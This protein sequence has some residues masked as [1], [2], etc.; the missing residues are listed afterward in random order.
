MRL[1]EYIMEMIERKKPYKAKE[2]LRTI[3][4]IRRI[5]EECDLFTLESHV[6]HPLPEVSSCRVYLGDQ[7]FAGLNIGTNGKGM[8]PRYALA[9][10]YGEW[11][12]RMQNGVLFPVRQLKFAQKRMAEEEGI[13]EFHEL[14]K[15]ENLELDFQ[16]GPDEIYLTAR[17]LSDCC[18]DILAK[19]FKGVS[20]D[21]MS[22]F[23][24]ESLKDMEIPCLPYFSVSTKEIRILPAKI[25]WNLCGT[26]GMSAGNTSEEA[27]IQGLS[28]VLERYAI[29]Q[30]YIERLTP[31]DI[32]LERY[33]G[34]Q[35]YERM[36]NL[37]RG[38]WKIAVKD[39]S[40]G[41]GLPVI[42]LL[43]ERPDGK[44]AFHLGADPSPV[45]ALERC[46]TE[47][48]QGNSKDNEQRYHNRETGHTDEKYWQRQYYETVECG[49][50][51]WPENIFFETPSYEFAGF[52]QSAGSSDEEDLVYITSLIQE[53]GYQIFV[54]DVSFLGI[55]AY[56]V[57]IPGMSETDFIFDFS[58]EDFKV[59]MKLVRSHRTMLNLTGASAQQ[60]RELA[61]AVYQAEQ[62]DMPIAFDIRRWFP[63][64]ISRNAWIQD[65]NYALSVIY[66][67][68][69]FYK[70]AARCMRDYLD[71]EASC[72]G[73][74]LYNQALAVYWENR[75]CGK[76]LQEIEAELSRDFNVSLAARIRSMERKNGLP[77]EKLFPTCFDCK[78]CGIYK[79]CRYLDILKIIKSIQE[80]HLL[81]M[82][83][84]LA[85]KLLWERERND[86]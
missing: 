81:Q 25:I 9:S 31:P 22:Q 29:R 5:L 33:K 77:D 79:D 35:I 3:N 60:R 64:N 74:R 21:G 70:E 8:T 82:P 85:L 37:T 72:R 7:R 39:C 2:P 15:K 13:E 17:E 67:A 56:Q 63:G 46:L 45:T 55:P 57:Y 41:K 86:R 12:E 75:A 66:A 83:D 73:Q 49:F 30:L 26:N 84:Q 18:S 48:F 58:H 32:P 51:K 27:L 36:G 4:E 1:R 53:A 43:A 6:A 10:A 34:T 59:W 40:L 65:G 19:V 38:G 14:L 16:Y 61:E 50:G 78:N 62:M 42:G 44:Y 20:E 76:D 80:K 24:E 47:L 54:R 69:G 71:S 11:I 68:G 28:E 23:M 52:S